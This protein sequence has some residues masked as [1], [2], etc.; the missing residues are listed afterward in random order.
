MELSVKLV[1]V[2]GHT[3]EQG[4]LRDSPVVLDCGANLGVFSCYQA[5][6]N[7][8]T[9]YAFEPDPRLF[10]N[11]PKVESVNFFN[12]AVSGHGSDLR[13][14]L[15]EEK[16]SSV[17]FSEGSEQASVIVKATRLDIFCEEKSL[18]RVDLL[19]LDIEGAELE[20]LELLPEKF[21][22]TTGQITVEFHDFLNKSD[23][24]RILCVIERLRECGFYFMKFSYHDYS[25]CLFINAKLH[26]L[27]VA[28][29]INLLF[30]KYFRGI[31]RKLSSWMR[32]G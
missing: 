26:P 27:G 25:D 8:A 23:V 30:R 31:M 18:S 3:F 28:E 19:K 1:N 17:C 21:L 20:V 9:V 16:C 11:L 24:P 2:C 4:F 32:R 14:N 7:H 6:K 29:K 15:G 22:A 10:P 5:K 13:L 12:L